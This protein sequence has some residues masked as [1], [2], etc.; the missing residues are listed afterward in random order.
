M[1]RQY[2]NA[3]K[4]TYTQENNIADLIDMGGFA[5]NSQRHIYYIGKDVYGILGIIDASE[6]PPTFGD[7]FEDVRGYL[8]GGW[9][10]LLDQKKDLSQ[11]GREYHISLKNFIQDNL[12]Q[13]TPR[14]L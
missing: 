5:L 10:E 3:M 4:D 9:Q 2:E 11:Y 13:L 7:S 6:C 1:I 14:T 8:P 12:P